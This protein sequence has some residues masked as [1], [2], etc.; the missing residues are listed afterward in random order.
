VEQ[1]LEEM[2]RDQEQY[3]RDYEKELKFLA[4]EIAGKVLRKIVS[5]NGAEMA[6]LVKGA[7]SSIKNA[8]WIQVEVSDRLVTL[9]HQL[10]RDFAS[11]EGNRRVEVVPKEEMPAD[12]CV[13][14]TPMGVLDASVPAQMEN[15]RA[16]FEKLD[17]EPGQD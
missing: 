3:F 13:I 8:E 1:V 6:E 4:L 2:R 7:V 9:V 16:V 5:E 17:Q 14:R 12:S 15:L 10:R 11:Q